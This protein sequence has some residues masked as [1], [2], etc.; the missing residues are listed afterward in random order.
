MHGPFRGRITSHVS[1]ACDISEAKNTSK[2]GTRKGAQT[3]LTESVCVSRNACLGLR[4]T[5]SWMESEL[6]VSHAYGTRGIT[7]FFLKALPRTCLVE[8]VIRL[9]SDATA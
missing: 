6:K 8:E 2:Y 3:I 4:L 9:T 5:S 1:Q 7:N